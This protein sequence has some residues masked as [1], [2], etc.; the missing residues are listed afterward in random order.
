VF[1]AAGAVAAWALLLGG[2]TY[3]AHAAHSITPLVGQFSS[4]LDGKQLAAVLVV[5]GTVIGAAGSFVSIRRFLH[6]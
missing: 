5:L 4:G 6:D 1:G 2:S 3:L